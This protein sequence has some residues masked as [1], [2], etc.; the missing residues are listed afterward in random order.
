MEAI[1]KEN[2]VSQTRKNFFGRKEDLLVSK[3]LYYLIINIFRLKSLTNK[4]SLG[5]HEKRSKHPIVDSPIC[6]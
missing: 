5:V 6:L 3:S 2:Q 4:A 1:S